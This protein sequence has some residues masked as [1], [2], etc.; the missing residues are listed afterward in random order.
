MNKRTQRTSKN[1]IALSRVYKALGSIPNTGWFHTANKHVKRCSMSY[2]VT[3]N[4]R[5][6]HTINMTKIQNSPTLQDT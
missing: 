3:Y 5:H 2:S 6:L 4:K 1:H